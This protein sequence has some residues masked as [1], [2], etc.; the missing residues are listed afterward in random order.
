[1]LLHLVLGAAALGILAVKV[2]RHHWRRF[3]AYHHGYA[4]GGCHGG[5][6]GWHGHHGHHHGGW[7]GGPYHVMAALDTTPGQEKVIREEISRLRERGRVA[8]DEASAARGDLAD[9][10]RADSFDRARFDAAAG[11]VDGAY[12]SLKG[13]FADSLARIHET[14]D[15]RQ[16]DKLAD[17]LASKRAPG[18]GPFR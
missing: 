16:R 17:F 9:L 11:R 1:M 4:Y 6:H 10:L 18:F 5:H 13:A 3:H 8:R 2:K 12:A 7:R 14:L 15:A